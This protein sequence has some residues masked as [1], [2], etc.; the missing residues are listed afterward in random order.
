MRIPCV[1]IMASG[2]HG[3]LHIG[4]TSHLAAR[5]IQHREGLIPGFTS[6]YRLMRLV[7][8]ET[9]DTMEAAI[10][11]EKQMKKWKRDW[12]LRLI[13][14]ANPHW[15]DLAIDLGLAPAPNGREQ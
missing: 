1:Y 9:A 10:R 12:K 4:V 13:E 14:E 7:W 11:R 2:Q 6:R 15:Q 3:T 5:V 8:F